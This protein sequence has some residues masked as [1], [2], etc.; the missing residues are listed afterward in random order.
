M[1]DSVDPFIAQLARAPAREPVALTPGLAAGQRLGR[2]ELLRELGRGGFGVVFEARDLEL[3]RHVAVKTARLRSRLPR[4]REEAA[5]VARL[6]HPNI[7]AL[8]DFGLHEDVPYLVMELIDGETL[9]ER[10][11]RGPL[12]LTEALEIAAQWLAALA[13]AHAAGVLHRDLKPGNVLLGSDGRARLVDL[14]LASIFASEQA[15]EK[16][17]EK[18]GTPGFAAPEQSRDGVEDERT[19]IFAA[20]ALLEAMLRG[21]D[22]IPG[23]LAGL[24]ARCKA[25]DPAG[26]PQTVQVLVTEIAAA[27][28]AHAR[29]TLVGEPFRWLEPFDT[30]DRGWFFG[31]DAESA[32]LVRLV[33][34]RPLCC[35]AGASGAG[36]SSLVRAGL[37]PRLRSGATQWS[38]VLVR[39]GREPLRNLREQVAAAL[40]PEVALAV[41]PEQQPGAFGVRL[42][43]QARVA[44]A[45]ILLAI[46]QFEE[47]YTLGAPAAER[48]VFSA[49]V[50]SAADNADGPVRAVLTIRED[51]LS[52][53]SEHPPLRDRVA[54]GMFL[55]VPPDRANLI[56]AVRGPARLGGFE[57]EAGVAEDMADALAGE[58]APLP[59]LELAASWMWQ[60]RDRERLVLPRAALEAIGGVAGVLATHAREVAR[61]LEPGDAVIARRI[62]AQLVTPEGTRRQAAVRELLAHEADPERAKRVVHTLVDGRLLTSS[63]SQRGEWVELAHEA[64][65]EG[66]DDL[67]RWVA[68]ERDAS[69]RK[70]EIAAASAAWEQRG[71]PRKLL[72]PTSELDEL[73]RWRQQHHLELPEAQESFLAVSRSTAERSQRLRGRVVAGVVIGL[74]LLVVLFGVTLRSYRHDAHEAK[75]A[76]LALAASEAKDPLVGAQLL[77]ELAEEGEPPGGAAA[78]VDISGKHIPSVV[79]SGHT[80][81]VIGAEFSPDGK[82]IATASRDGTG[83]LWPSDGNGPARVLSGHTGELTSIAF[84]RDGARVVTASEDGTARVWPVA[85]GAPRVL[86]GHHGKVSGAVFAPTGERVLTWSDDGTARV[87]PSDGE[88][89]VLQGGGAALRHASFSAD[90]L[91]VAAG[92]VSGVAWLWRADGT[93]EALALRGHLSD[94]PIVVVRFAPDGRQLLTASADRT[95]RLWPLEVRGGAVSS[96]ESVVL[97]GHESDIVDAR[98]DDTG[99]VIATGSLDGTVRTWHARDGSAD[100]VLRVGSL[101]RAIAF[102]PGQRL[103]AALQPSVANVWEMGDGTGS[104]QTFLHPLETAGSMRV[105]AFS[106]DGKRLLT[107]TE[108][109]VRVFD[110][111]QHVGPFVR[112]PHTGTLYSVQWPRLGGRILTASVDGNAVIADIDGGHA[113]VLPTG[114]HEGPGAW[115]NHDGQRVVAIA[116]RSASSGA[117][118]V[119]DTMSGAMRELHLPVVARQ[120]RFLGNTGSIAVRGSDHSLFVVEPD[121]TITLLAPS[122][123]KAKPFSREGWAVFAP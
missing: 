7:V 36:K 109:T 70:A 43:E 28:E 115:F 120:A 117:L 91:L 64:L 99:R 40:G 39:P 23:R 25:E 73:T 47:I 59:L 77:L 31:R 8:H 58:V 41:G 81:W 62:S 114:E 119:F 61:Q 51:Y 27:R 15:L 103:A 105:V 26:R 30:G 12:S 50:V 98:F 106:A 19:D 79:L 56:E 35:V 3:G 71:R 107:A 122:M 69:R 63:R 53:L 24:I 29:A 60:R 112:R 37:L 65:I 116:N 45:N 18:G 49:M 118:R 67:R 111:E 100:R 6:A 72:W 94:K 46:D 85:G 104:A 34:S 108:R 84:S 21:A 113:L 38:V 68:E 110:L 88:P 97:R 14:G 44:G 123:P 75:R 32:R 2:F 92:D 22:P 101:V 13:H 11:A 76:R 1:S 83:R 55:L 52:R 74:A 42:R 48:E 96:R 66:W 17:P 78:A 86:R 90:G 93:G 33:Q 16:P 5:A 57:V 4:L 95:V 80:S 20:G 9:A 87:W 54:A 10:L 102:G 89:V 82:L 121:A